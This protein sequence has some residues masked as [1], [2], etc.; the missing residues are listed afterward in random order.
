MGDLQESLLFGPYPTFSS[1]H[2][3]MLCSG[4]EVLCPVR[5]SLPSAC[6][7]HSLPPHPPTD[8]FFLI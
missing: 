3:W 7:Q 4:E 1:S 6:E 8:H 5:C 2:G